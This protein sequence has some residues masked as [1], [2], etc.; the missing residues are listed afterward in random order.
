MFTPPQL[1]PFFSRFN[2]SKMAREI[3][4]KDPD[5]DKKVKEIGKLSKNK[6]NK[7]SFF[8]SCSFS[9]LCVCMCLCL[10]VCVRGGNVTGSPNGNFPAFYKQGGKRHRVSESQVSRSFQTGGETSQSPRV[11]KILCCIAPVLLGIFPSGFLHWN[12]HFFLF[13]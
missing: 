8:P 9:T 3:D 11:F 6:F 1:P 13:S 12:Q 4:Q 10:F 2:V 7:F 5:L